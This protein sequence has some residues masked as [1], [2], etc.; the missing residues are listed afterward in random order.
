M[1]EK[2]E[3]ILQIC[4]F[5]NGCSAKDLPNSPYFTRYP[6][7]LSM[8]IGER[9]GFV[10]DGLLVMIL[11]FLAVGLSFYFMF[12]RRAGSALQGPSS[13]YAVSP[14]NGV[15]PSFILFREMPGTLFGMALVLT[16]VGV[17][18]SVKDT[19]KYAEG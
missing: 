1:A 6:F 16:A 3:G 17:Y 5:H 15:L 10:R 9:I 11:G 18:P 2:T 7:L 4:Y 12:W 19:E 13:Y 8:M 14:F